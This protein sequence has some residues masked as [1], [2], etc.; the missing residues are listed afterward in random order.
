MS[1]KDIKVVLDDFILDCP[2]WIIDKGVEALK[3]ILDA[4]EIKELHA[5]DPRTW[6]ALAHHGWGTR[7]RNFLRDKVCRD[8]ELPSKNWDDYYIQI[9]E[10]ACGC[11]ERIT[12]E[13]NL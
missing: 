1:D 2:I 8:E 4:N 12:D 9:V 11:R 5:K 6:W 7:V 10:I 3:T 13:T